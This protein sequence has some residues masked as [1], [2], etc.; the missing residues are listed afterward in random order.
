MTIPECP[1]GFYGEYCSHTCECHN[2]ATCDPSTG[3]CRCL[4][5]YTGDTCAQVCPSGNVYK[6]SSVLCDM[7]TNT[8]QNNDELL[9]S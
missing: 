8:L 5:G 3:Q 4:P 6:M 2:G 7:N 1:G 9:E